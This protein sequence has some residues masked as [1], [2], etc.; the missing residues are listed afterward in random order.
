MDVAVVVVPVFEVCKEEKHLMSSRCAVK[1]LLMFS[2][3]VL[4]LKMEVVDFSNHQSLSVF[5]FDY[6]LYF[7][8]VYCF[9]FY[10]KL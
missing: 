8:F 4:L 10:E 2:Y 5:L 7:F 3:I 1:C 9:T 6:D